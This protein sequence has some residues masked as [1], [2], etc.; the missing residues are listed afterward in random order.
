MLAAHG[1][2]SAIVDVY[3]KDLMDAWITA[4]LLKNKMIY[5]D[6]YLES[7]RQ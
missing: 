4:D 5:N 6:S 3:D 2:K 1:M 7:A